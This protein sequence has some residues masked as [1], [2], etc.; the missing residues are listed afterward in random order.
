MPLLLTTRT[1]GI[2]PIFVGAY[3]IGGPID[4]PW[5][6][7]IGDTVTLR[8]GSVDIL[9]R[10]FEASARS[11]KGVIVGF[12]NHDDIEYEGAKADDVIE[13]R[14]EHLIACSH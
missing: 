14:Y 10:I 7:K 11:Y 3:P 1:P 4:S 13:F 6:P 9:A 2:G 5:E 12:E 8:S